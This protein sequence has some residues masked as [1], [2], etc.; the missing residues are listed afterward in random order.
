MKIKPLNN[1]DVIESV[2]AI[3]KSVKAYLVG[4]CVR[5]WYLKKKC[6]DIDITFSIYPQN[7]AEELAKKYSMKI[8]SFKS[9]MTLRLISE[10]LRIDLATFRKEKYPHPASLPV[11]EKAF[12]IEE[13]LLRRDFSV[14]AVAVSINESDM[15]EVRDPF[16]GIED[17]KKGVI[18]VLH[19]K[20]FKDDPTRIFRAVRFSERFNW[21][22]EGKTHKLLTD[23]VPYIKF[24]S[25]ERIRNEIIKI[26]SEK[27]C[28]S[29]LKKIID[30]EILKK[31]ELFEFDKSID[32]L[33]TTEERFIYIAKRNGMSF[34]EKYAFE[35]SIKN[36]LKKLLNTKP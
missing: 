11:V 21:Q 5:D 24:L 22:I 13:D 23:S 27:R 32:N 16:N 30:L 2:V 7:I 4:G 28:Y 35:R 15:F 18:R 36:K 19:E 31:E 3:K 12:S 26:L 20:S 1:T 34:F 6:F 33:K 25:K 29:T 8:E 10:N 17:I 9:F 14:N